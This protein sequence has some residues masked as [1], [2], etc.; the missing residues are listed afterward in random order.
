MNTQTVET[1]LKKCKE[2]MVELKW[3]QRTTAKAASI[4]R[5]YLNRVLSGKKKPGQAVMKRLGETLGVR[6]PNEPLVP[7]SDSLPKKESFTEVEA[8]MAKALNYFRLG[9]KELEEID[10]MVERVV[11]DIGERIR[12][13][14]GL[15]R[16]LGV[17]LKH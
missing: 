15:K 14:S 16:S 11:L 6:V 13:S 3:S 1:F 8:K 4:N 2:K 7:A 9:A 12:S 10:E 17:F 5:A